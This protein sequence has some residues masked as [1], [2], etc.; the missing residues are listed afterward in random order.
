MLTVRIHAHRTPPGESDSILFTSNLIA[1]NLKPNNLTNSMVHITSYTR[2]FQSTTFEHY[3]GA[4][5]KLQNTM[6][7]GRLS[8]DW[9]VLTYS[10]EDAASDG[11]N[12]GLRPLCDVESVAGLFPECC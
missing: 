2:S 11:G 3:R 12:V 10:G 7:T 9:F 6:F 5:A 8:N 1:K 4:S